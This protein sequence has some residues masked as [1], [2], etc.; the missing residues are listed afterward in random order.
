VRHSMHDL[1]QRAYNDC[2]L[3]GDLPSEQLPIVHGA[4]P[5]SYQLLA[6]FDG[7]AV[8]STA[9]ARHAL[10]QIGE[11]YIGRHPETLEGVSYRTLHSTVSQQ[12]VKWYVAFRE[13]HRSARMRDGQRFVRQLERVLEEG[14]EAITHY[15]PCQLFMSPGPSIQIGP[16][17]LTSTS[18]WLEQ[19]KSELSNPVWID[20]ERSHVEA[21][22]W[23]AEVPVSASEPRRSL[24][25]ARLALDAL[26][27]VFGILFNV[28]SSQMPWCNDQA[29]RLNTYISLTRRT[30]GPNPWALMVGVNTNH[31][32]L[33]H[34]A[35]ASAFLQSRREIL[36]A[37]GRCLFTFV[38]NEA[39]KSRIPKLHRRWVE[40]MYWYGEGLHAG[41][42]GV[43]VAKFETALEVLTH[44]RS[45]RATHG[46]LIYVGSA[47]LRVSLDHVIIDDPRL[48][49]SDFVQRFSKTRSEIL[50]GNRHTFFGTIDSEQQLA[51]FIVGQILLI[52][53]VRL[54]QYEA[55]ANPEDTFQGF[56][57]WDNGSS[58][59]IAPTR[60][61]SW[62]ATCGRYV[63]TKWKSI[64]FP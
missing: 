49:Y 54:S 15:V 38:G 25:H 41:L 31:P 63:I 8:V 17:L 51:G 29:A 5:S 23:V 39:P 36:D 59:A 64:R 6:M 19:H 44:A 60:L 57:R 10:H 42:P 55:T 22:G 37:V 61:P 43:A 34:G 2:K 28:D 16:V 1:L 47:W 53:A 40:S 32:I 27:G 52:C 24:D 58:A 26:F 21:F 62:L 7:V 4:T 12:F 35:A 30:D 56:R 20:V 46:F 11:R 9:K 13:Q 48:T 50:H 3:I 18:E 33:M 14:K 45:T